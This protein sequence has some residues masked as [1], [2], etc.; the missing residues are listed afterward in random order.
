MGSCLGL[1]S[2]ACKRDVCVCVCAATAIGGLG[3]AATP[4][5]A[6]CC[7][8]D[9]LITTHC[10]QTL[11]Q[12]PSPSTAV[13][14]WL[15]GRVR[16]S[17]PRLIPSNL[18]GRASFCAPSPSWWRAPPRS[19]AWPRCADGRS[20]RIGR[21]P[22]EGQGT[23]GA[24]GL[25]D[26]LF[27]P[28]AS[29]SPQHSPSQSRR[30]RSRPGTWTIRTRTSACRTGEPVFFVLVWRQPLRSRAR[31]PAGVARRARWCGRTPSRSPRQTRRPAPLSVPL[32][33]PLTR[34]HNQ[35]VPVQHP[36]QNAKIITAKTTQEDARRAVLGGRAARPGRALLADGRARRVGDGR[37]AGVH[38][39]G[40]RVLLH[41]ASRPRAGGSFF[42]TSNASVDGDGDDER[43]TFDA[44]AARVTK[45]EPQ[46]QKPQKQKPHRRSSTS[47]A[48]P[49]RTTTPRSTPSTRSTYTPTMRSATSSAAAA[50]L[51]CATPEIGGCGSPA[52]AEI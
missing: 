14:A 15:S 24:I 11:A 4:P 35:S 37:Q 32:R 19:S 21:S 6:L 25:P 50:T 40:P 5:P 30:A 18:L 7:A 23:L 42:Q 1:V 8:N 38:P 36:T 41:G 22:R 27:S 10:R 20:K 17:L 44:A 12:S 13:A 49:S 31:S 3:V 28:D 26:S 52:A 2:F 29:T 45:K 16:S 43:E 47:A 33:R 34:K 9:S 39:Q 46:K 48:T 51:T